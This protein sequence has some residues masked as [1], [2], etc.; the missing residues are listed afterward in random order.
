MNN[1]DRWSAPRAERV[2]ALAGIF[3]AMSLVQQMARVG[4]VEQASF[5][6]SIE[7]LFIIDAPTIE[8]IYRGPQNLEAGLNILCQQF[9]TQRAQQD[10]ELT[11]YWLSLLF[12]ERKLMR[13]SA[14]LDTIRQ[15][16][17]TAEKQASLFSKTHDNVIARLADI[18]KNTVSTL[19]PRIMVRGEPHF[20]N[21]PANANKIRAL[22]L[23]AL[24]STIL[25]RQLGGNRW[26]LLFGKAAIVHTAKALLENTAPPVQTS[27]L[28]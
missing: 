2:M 20:L 8:A 24:R 21:Q 3:Q 1:T 18:Y 13:R 17:K 12:L 5:T 22:L 15:G 6:T 16:I 11:Y 7:S 10:I 19:N 9:D 28:Q 4:E 26:N 23:A 14:L 27:H 25:W